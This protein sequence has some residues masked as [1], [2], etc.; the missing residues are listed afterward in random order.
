MSQITNRVGYQQFQQHAKSN[1]QFSGHNSNHSAAAT[2]SSGI[3]NRS[4]FFCCGGL[5]YVAIGCG[6]LIAIAAGL[7]FHKNLASLLWHRPKSYVY[8]FP[9]AATSVVEGAGA[10]FKN[11]GR[12]IWS[13]TPGT[14]LFKARREAL[15]AAK[16]SFKGET[17]GELVAKKVKVLQ[18][19]FKERYAAVAEKA[20]EAA[21]TPSNP[22]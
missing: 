7:I 10:K 4:N 16:E 9:K 20:A 13:R 15:E 8:D 1:V 11:F 6:A 19:F 3:D 5:E 12:Y 22:A 21:P 18:N 17:G 2:P 14:E